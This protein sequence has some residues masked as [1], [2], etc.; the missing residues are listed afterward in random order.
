MPADPRPAVAPL[1]FSGAARLRPGAQRVLGEWLAWGLGAW[2]SAVGWDAAL[3]GA[4]PARLAGIGTGLGR[5]PP[6][7]AA[8]VLSGSSYNHTKAEECLFKL[9]IK[10]I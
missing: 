7:V 1:T 9:E 2:F 8:G 10:A 4:L 6:P 5:L 3:A